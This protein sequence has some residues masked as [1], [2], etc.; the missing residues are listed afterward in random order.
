MPRFVAWIAGLSILLLGLTVSSQGRGEQEVSR[1]TLVIHGG[2]GTIT[3]AQM[4]PDREAAYT[5]A[6]GEALQAG[7]QI[8][9]A[10]GTSLDA[11][12]AAIRVMEDQPL[13]NAG[14]GSVLTAEGAVELDASIMDGAT[15][16]AGAVAGVTRIKNPI[17]AARAV[18]DRSRHVM[19]QGG[20][21]DVFAEA[22]GLELVP[23]GY[24]HTER[25]RLQLEQV[26]QGQEALLLDHDADHKYGTV[27][28]AALDTHG[29]LAAGTSTGGMTNKMFGRVGDSPIIG[30]GTYANNA[31]CAVS[32]TGQGEYFI[33]ATVARDICALMEYAGLSLAEAARR[34]VQDTLT[35]LG[36]Q[37]GIIAVDRDGGA[38][39]EFNTEG[40][41][42]ARVAH[43]TDA[44]IAIYRD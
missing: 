42:R 32:G 14:K 4:T 17:L 39:F 11:V 24:F 23:N 28:A 21:A 25:R 30:A 27:G 6:L 38:V 31:S 13:F 22:Q 10:G 19:L 5:A 29:N 33:R 26:K 35:G 37:G 18:M 1:Y 15:R 12:V 36:G 7:Q 16:Q 34:V 20:G 8:L 3:R 9:A 2:A 44:E 40:M 41:Y 43:D